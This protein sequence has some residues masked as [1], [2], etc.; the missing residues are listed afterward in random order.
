MHHFRSEMRPL[1][2][3]VDW[4]GSSNI[5]HLISHPHFELIRHDVTFPLYV[6]LRA[7][8][9]PFT[10]NVT[11]ILASAAVNVFLAGICRCAQRAVQSFDYPTNLNPTAAKW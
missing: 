7:L 4:I 10:I 6:I 3:T 8:L 2:H 5:E 9:R 1:S 11:R